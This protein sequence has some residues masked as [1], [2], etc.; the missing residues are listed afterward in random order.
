MYSYGEFGPEHLKKIKTGIELFN[1]K[2]YWECHEALEEL[3]LE[4]RQDYARYVYW[5][6][7]QVAAAMVHYQNNNLEGARSLIKKS[8]NKFEFLIEKNIETDLIF[9]FL[10]WKELKELVYSIPENGELADFKKLY[11]FSFD[12]YKEEA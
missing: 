5:A 9:R 6:V 8:K 12:Q 10:S 3:W 2:L 1:Q 4:D 11:Q 7:I